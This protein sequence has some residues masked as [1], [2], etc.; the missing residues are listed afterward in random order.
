VIGYTYGTSK[1]IWVNN[2]YFVTNADTSVASNLFHEWLH[3]VGFG[4]AVSYSV[5]R[6]YSV[7][8]AI[9]RLIGSIGKQFD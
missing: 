2:K 7:P 9:G 8:Y 4:H 3:K 1:R 6:D 5:S